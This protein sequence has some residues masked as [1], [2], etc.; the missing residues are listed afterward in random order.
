M[1]KQIRDI[2][3]EKAVELF[4]TPYDKVSDK[5]RRIAKVV[6]FGTLYGINDTTLGELIRGIR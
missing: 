4:G 6:N 3:K 5:Q 1:D 2:H